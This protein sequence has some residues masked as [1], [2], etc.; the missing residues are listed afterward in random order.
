MPTSSGSITSVVTV[1]RSHPSQLV[2]TCGL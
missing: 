2:V 1:C